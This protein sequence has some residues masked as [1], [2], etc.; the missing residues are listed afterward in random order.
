MNDLNVYISKEGSCVYLAVKSGTDIVRILITA[1][2]V[3]NLLAL[4]IEIKE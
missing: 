1:G 2:D 4:G 3:L